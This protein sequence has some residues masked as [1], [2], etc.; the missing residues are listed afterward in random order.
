MEPSTKSRILDAAESLF[1]ELGFRAASMRVVTQEAGTNLAAVNYHFGSKEGLIAA[2]FERRLG[3]INAERLAGLDALQQTDADGP[4]PELE[5]ILAVFLRPAFRLLEDPQA[6]QFPRLLGRIHSDPDRDKVRELLFEQMV[7]LRDRFVPAF[8]RSLGC[9]DQVELMWHLHFLIGAMAHTLTCAD[10]IE[11][12]SEGRM[13]TPPPEELLR[14]LVTF[15]AA[16]I[17]A[18]VAPPGDANPG[19]T[20]EPR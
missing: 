18:G 6:R 12:I 14:R 7:E 17:R 15:A 3:P 11:W 5:A 19:T 8:A 16:G 1:A 2:V 9:Q 20:E 10:D 13:Q 4:S